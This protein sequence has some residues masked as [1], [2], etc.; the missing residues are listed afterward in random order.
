LAKSTNQL[1]TDVKSL[2]AWRGLNGMSQISSPSSELSE[3]LSKG[4][5]V[6]LGFASGGGGATAA[7]REWKIFF[8]RFLFE[9]A[10]AHL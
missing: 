5:G 2:L 1:A 4:F 9:T 10:H 3:L 7:A 6:G 8:S